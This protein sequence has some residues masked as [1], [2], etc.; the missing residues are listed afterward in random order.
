MRLTCFMLANGYA[1]TKLIDL[2]TLNVAG[3][4]TRFVTQPNPSRQQIRSTH[5]ASQMSLH[6]I[7]GYKQNPHIVNSPSSWRL[8]S[9][10]DPPE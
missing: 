9:Q 1:L 10:V 7:C 4:Q 5:T 3:P 8:P 2:Q 6:L